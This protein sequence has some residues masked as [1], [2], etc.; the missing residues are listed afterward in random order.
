MSGRRQRYQPPDVLKFEARNPRRYDGSSVQEW[1]CVRMSLH[2][3]SFKKRR[4]TKTLSSFSGDQSSCVTSQTSVRPYGKAVNILAE[5]GIRV[6]ISPQLRNVS[7]PQTED[8]ESETEST[9]TAVSTQQDD[10]TPR[11]D[12]F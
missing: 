8:N 1:F 6:E 3:I 10:V 7:F 12:M 11:I 5:N 9:V 4:D 2:A